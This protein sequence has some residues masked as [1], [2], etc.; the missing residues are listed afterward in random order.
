MKVRIIKHLVLIMSVFSAL[1]FVSSS[2]AALPE[3]GN[4]Y[5]TQ[6]GFFFEKGKHITTNYGRGEFVPAN[7]QVQVKSVKGKRMVLTYKG[8]DITIEN[9]E[10]YTNKSITE[11]GDRML[12]NTPV[13]IGGRFAKDIAMGVMRLGMTKDEVIQTR[14]YPP[15]HKTPSTDYDTWVYWSSRFVQLSL[16]FENGRLT[17]GRGL[18]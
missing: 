17:Q 5:Y 16:V 11:V 2:Q 8:Q 18:R 1:F 12:S 7:S 14:G 6:H 13:A 15:A 10:K 9:A 3:V 4:S